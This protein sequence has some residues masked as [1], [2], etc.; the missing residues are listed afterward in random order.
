[1][2]LAVFTS[3]FPHR[4]STFFARD[5]RGLIDAGVEVDVYPIY[6]VDEGQWRYVP[7]I[8]DET[9]LPRSRVH[10]VGIGESLRL[11]RPWAPTS[12]RWLVDTMR[13]AV[14]AARYGP[15][16]FVKSMYVT[17]AGRAWARQRPGRY[18]HILAY[19]GNYAATA[20][21]VFQRLTDPSV[22][23][24]IMLHAGTDLY[25]TPVFLRQKL[26]YADNVLVPCEF[27]RR[28]ISERY[29]RDGEVVSSKVHVHHLGLD[30]ATYA[31]SPAG[32]E[33]RLVLAAGGFERVKG[34][35]Y[36]LR[37]VAELR[38]RG[39]DVRLELIGDGEQAVALRSLARTTGIDGHVRFR[40][41]LT[42]EE[43]R[44]A[45]LRASIL[46]HPSTG[47]GDAV[48]TVIKEALAL[49]TPVVASSVA[50]IPELLDD[51]RC[52]VLVPPRQVDALADAIGE[53]LSSAE[54]RRDLAHA[55]RLH[56]ERTFDIWR[57]G[58]RLAAVLGATR[59]A[60]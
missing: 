39:V 23:Y 51:G 41:W 55:G 33:P 26:R 11:A 54:R 4:V 7:A 52:G 45:M 20:A 43:V 35:D 14:S 59:R 36:L 48:P 31:F 34:F 9:V 19:W 47:L 53:L 5:M 50:G 60:T 37:A 40:G 25:R 38:R 17:M 2:R 13:I 56:A 22:P 10:D 16:P 15:S 3:K 29:D 49:G 27:N 42:P 32:R 18:D 1:M 46:V 8:L 12:S 24:S 30:C 57:N 44:Q 28:F 21:Y 58:R 6:P